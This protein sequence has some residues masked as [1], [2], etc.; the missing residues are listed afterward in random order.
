VA[1]STPPD[2]VL[3]DIAMLVMD[4]RQ[5]A[6]RLRLNIASQDCLIIGITG[7]GDRKC[8]QQCHE[9]G[10]DL[11]LLKPADPAVVE[12]LLLLECTRVNRLQIPTL[13]P[14]YTNRKPYTIYQ[15]LTNA[16]AKPYQRL[17]RMTE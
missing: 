8:R 5:I 15:R 4:G 6:P 13:R 16:T 14:C 1:K 12:T 17:F 7:R 2:V 9:V 11:V 3:L 10:I